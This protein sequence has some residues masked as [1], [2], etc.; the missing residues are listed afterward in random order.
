M[1]YERVKSTI[2]LQQI[3]FVANKEYIHIIEVLE[4]K[5][6][7]KS[8]ENIQHTLKGEKSDKVEKNKYF[9]DT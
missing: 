5:F 7:E 1:I 4:G 8:I 9:F 6:S 3:L 2:I